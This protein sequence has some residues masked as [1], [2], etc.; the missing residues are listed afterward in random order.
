[1]P[2]PAKPSVALVIGAPLLAFA[3]ASC[4]KPPAKDI[5]K[6]VRF[7]PKPPDP[8]AAEMRRAQGIL[9]EVN[10]FRTRN[11]LK[12]LI[13][14]AHLMLAAKRHAQDI[15]KDY[16]LS[17]RG[18]DGTLVEDRV[19]ETGYRYKL[20]AE[21]IAASR[22]TFRGTVQQWQISKCHRYAMMMPRMRHAGVAYV[23]SRTGRRNPPFR[24]WWVLIMA[25]PSS[26][27]DYLEI[28]YPTRGSEL[29]VAAVEKSMAIPQR[30]RIRK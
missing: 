28:T 16:R 17:H 18:S 30:C 13:L 22:S 20:V 1:M 25:D 23:Y 9:E 12:P 8:T 2:L 5:R 21:N 4:G 15:V 6:I 11:G 7:K 3:L 24:H 10:R 14:E 19:V 27:M 29:P 26:W